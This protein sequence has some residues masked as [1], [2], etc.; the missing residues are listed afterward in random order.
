MSDVPTTPNIS[1]ADLKYMAQKKAHA[2]LEAQHAGCRIRLEG[3]DAFSLDKATAEKLEKYA[4]M[5]S[6]LPRK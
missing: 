4:D 6:K 1:E 3:D 5:R 2:R